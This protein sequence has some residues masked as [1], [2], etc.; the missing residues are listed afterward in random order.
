[1][2]EGQDD[3]GVGED[4]DDDGG[5]AVEQVCGVADDEGHGA[6]A[7]FGEIDAAEETYWHTDERREKKKLGAADDGVGHAAAG[8]ADRSGELGEEGPVDGCSAVVHEIAEDEEEHGHGDEGG[9]A[10]HAEHEAADK[11]AVAQAGGHVRP[12]SLPRW[13]VRTMSRR[14]RP[15]RTK[16]RMKR[17]RPSSIRDCR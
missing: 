17:T 8:F 9:Q 10:G 5:D 13:A 3:Q 16:V 11:F 6:A 1:M 2:F 12:I 7:E 14:A 15:L 4:A